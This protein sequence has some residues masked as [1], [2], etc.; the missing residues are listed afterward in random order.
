MTHPLHE[1]V[2]A[3]LATV[4]D[5]EIRRPITDL[6]MVDSVVIDEAGIAAITVLLTVSGCPLK[7]TIN[8]DVTAAVTKVPG[9]TGV[10][11][12]L[13]VMSPEQRA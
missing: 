2:L 7:D 13:G 4:N 10:D 6:G 1:A 8:R 5:P 11:L 12:T 9:I 3:A